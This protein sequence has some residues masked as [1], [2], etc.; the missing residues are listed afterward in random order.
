MMFAGKRFDELTIQ[1]I[2]SLQTEEVRECKY[3]DYKRQLPGDSYDD[4]KELLRDVS[5]FA[6][7]N[8]GYIIYGVNDHE[9]LISEFVWL[10]GINVDQ[11]KL[12]LE[13]IIQ[14]GIIPRVPGVSIREI[15]SETNE[16]RLLIVYI[17]QSWIKPHMVNL[18]IAG[19][20]RFWSRS[21]AGKYPL[22]YEQIKHEMI[23][24]E[25]VYEKIKQF[26]LNRISS[27]ISAETPVDTVAG[28][29]LVLHL[30]PFSYGTPGQQYTLENGR[31]AG[32]WEI[33]PIRTTGWDDRPNIDGR[34][35]W[36]GARAPTY[37]YT[38]LF[39]HGCI[40]AINTSLL[41]IE[42]GVKV[43]SPEA[44]EVAIIEATQNYM[45][46]M[47][48]VGIEPPIFVMLTFIDVKGFMLDQRDRQPHKHIDRDLLLIPEIII[49]EYDAN[50][51]Q[52]LKPIFDT[53]WNAA[54]YP[55]SQCYN[56]D[57][58]RIPD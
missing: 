17:P 21:S 35:F 36:A 56:A 55:R 14:T 52:E 24:S 46:F 2:R 48:R 27:I 50:I 41:M 8:G 32:N 30:I 4:K 3:V 12:R 19:S 53:F 6:N 16:Q 34:V 1:D 13:Q 54:G 9:G 42:D 45:R 11:A 26:R 40:E 47:R 23:H 25:V 38:Q 39:R 15:P 44:C 7:T 57:G 10:P 31:N 28:P 5:S 22:D 51:A 33:R 29:K 43:I 18:Q 58:T 20:E 49:K 37:A